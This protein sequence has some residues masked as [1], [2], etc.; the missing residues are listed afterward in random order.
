METTDKKIVNI[1]H[2]IKR[3]KHMPLLK[4]QSSIQDNQI[5]FMELNTQSGLLCIAYDKRLNYTIPKDI[6]NGTI[7]RWT[8]PTNTS[9]NT[10]LVLLAMVEQDMQYILD[11]I[12]IKEHM[13]R[14]SDIIKKHTDKKGYFMANNGEDIWENVRLSLVK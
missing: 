10:A 12:D 3:I 6:L 4:K 11:K 13:Q 5:C 1:C 7:I 9:R 14:V 8:L 2:E